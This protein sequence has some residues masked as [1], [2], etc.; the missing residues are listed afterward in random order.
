MLK[1]MSFHNPIDTYHFFYVEVSL[2]VFNRSSA[3]ELM[4]SCLRLILRCYKN[5][6]T[7]T[8]LEIC[9]VSV[10]TDYERKKIQHRRSKMPEQEQ[11]N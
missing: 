6:T 11:G 2:L 3:R 4:R 7:D 10:V 8:V 9:N 1:Q 5:G